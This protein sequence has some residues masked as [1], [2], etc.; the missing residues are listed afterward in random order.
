[1]LTIFL[2]CYS[3]LKRFFYIYFVCIVYLYVCMY[4]YYTSI[5]VWHGTCVEAR[6]QFVSQFFVPTELVLGIELRSLVL[7][8]LLPELSRTLFILFF[9]TGCLVQPQA[10]QLG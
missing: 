1:M 6:G 7:A 4:V 10:H 8:P 2:E 3:T 9:E 5:L